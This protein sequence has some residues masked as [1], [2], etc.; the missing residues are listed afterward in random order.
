MA[1]KPKTND[2]NDIKLVDSSYYSLH[3]QLYQVLRKLIYTGRWP[4]GSKIPSE[5]QLANHLNISRSTVRLAL[6]RAELEG[7]IHR[8]S[9]K[10]TFVA[11]SREQSTH[12]RFIAFVISQ[13]INEWTAMLLK[14]AESE[15]RE[16]GH[17]IVYTR[18]T[19]EQNTVELLLKLQEESIA[20]VLLWPDILPN[21][22]EEK[23]ACFDQLHIP[24]VL[25]DRP[26]NGLALD[27]VTSENYAGG[28][29]IMRH[30][31]ELGH[32]EI[33]FLSHQLIS[34]HTIAERLRAY[35]DAMQSAGLTPREP[36][37]VGKLEEEMSATQV[38]GTET[39]DHGPDVLR[40]IQYIKQADPPPT[41]IFAANDT[42]AVLA[43]WA[44]DVMDWHIPDDLSLVGFDDQPFAAYMQVPL[45][46]ISQ[47]IFT[48]GQKAAH[49]LIHRLEGWDG[50]A[51]MEY[52]PTRLHIRQSTAPP[53]IN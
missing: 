2:I 38:F 14:G 36:W 35:R 48:M 30:L 20:G 46:T 26:I 24:V 50:P 39:V 31:L 11:F 5:T 23:A 15:A 3:V 45:T 28:L 12:S 19:P 29:R 32:K 22:I 27:C 41:A 6:Q 8:V 25:V 33:V 1:P 16:R 37:L 34:I 13:A 7:L 18:K 9:G 42:M 49:L 51:R 47:D 52:I 53:P 43:A 17:R 10:G 21:D 4:H 40:I 44:L